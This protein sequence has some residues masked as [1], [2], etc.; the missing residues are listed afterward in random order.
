MTPP[1]C[2]AVRHGGPRAGLWVVRQVSRTWGWGG[3]NSPG[4]PGG[5]PPQVP[6]RPSLSVPRGHGRGAWCLTANRNLPCA[7]PIADQGL[8]SG[9]TGFRPVTGSDDRDSGGVCPRT[10]L[11]PP[12]VV[13]P[14]RVNNYATGLT[15]WCG[16][17]CEM[18]VKHA[19][20]RPWCDTGRTV[21]AGSRSR[22]RGRGSS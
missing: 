18:Y 12:T 11:H 2:A 22:G 17:W 8:S 6:R 10:P 21:V 15:A 3:E 13:A 4:S 14:K 7:E 5:P 9:I 16:S 19:S 1:V 20:E